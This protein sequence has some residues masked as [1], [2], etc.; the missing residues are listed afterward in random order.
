MPFNG[1]GSF[2]PPGADFPAVANTLIEAAKFNAI[3]NDM[4]TGLSTCIT[5]DGQTTVT[6]N[7][8]MANHKFTGLSAGSASGD[9]LRYE[10]VNGVVTT[11][12]DILYATGAGVLARAGIGT[13]GQVLSVNAG[14]TAPAYISALNSRIYGNTYANSAVDA[15]NDIDIA[16]GGCIDATGA[17]WMQGGAITKQLDAAWAVGT[18]QGG[19]DTGSIGNSDY[20]IWRIG[21]SDTGVVDALFSLS[22]TAPTMPAN[23][24]F[25][26]LV[27]WFKRV[28]A[29]I[30]G[31]KTFEIEGGGIQ[32]NWNAPTADINLSNTLT[33]SRRTDA[34]KVPLNF[35]VQANLSVILFDASAVAQVKIMCP[36]ETD[37]A[38]SGS[39]CNANIVTTSVQSAYQMSIRTSSTGTIAARTNLATV[40]SY[41]VLTTGFNWARR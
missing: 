19:L 21:R 9:S 38:V 7:I 5:K 18:N 32:M 39:N 31:F 17:Y 41:V 2:S 14:A 20:Y 25:K 6:A 16:A 27:G 35:S 40:D 24:D 13:A 8:P 30:V 29:T 15:T 12:G 36:D 1:S 33:T 10:Q 4:A 3:I 22:A 34:V 37:A 11:A 23:Y 26:R 28:G